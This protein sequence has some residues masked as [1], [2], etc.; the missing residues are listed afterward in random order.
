MNLSFGQIR[1]NQNPRGN[2]EWGSWTNGPQDIWGNRE[3]GYQHV[4]VPGTK[5]PFEALGHMAY[6]YIQ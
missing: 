5:G 2:T 4:L 1:T 6:R 3:Y